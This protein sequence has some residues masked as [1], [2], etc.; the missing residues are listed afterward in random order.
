MPS[1]ATAR[2]VVK[3]YPLETPGGTQ[4]FA[5]IYESDLYD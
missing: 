4:E 3:R 5:F 2:G 1:S